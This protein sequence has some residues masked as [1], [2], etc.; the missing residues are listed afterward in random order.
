MRADIGANSCD[1]PPEVLHRAPCHGSAVYR[2]D[3]SSG[4]IL[5]PVAADSLP[6]AGKHPMSARRVMPES[7]QRM[8]GSYEG[9]AGECA[10]AHLQ[11]ALRAA[12]GHDVGGL[13]LLVQAKGAVCRVLSRR[14]HL[15]GAAPQAAVGLPCLVPPATSESRR[16][17]RRVS[18]SNNTAPRSYHAHII[19]SHDAARCGPDRPPLPQTTAYIFHSEDALFSL[20]SPIISAAC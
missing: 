4:N 8:R 10:A 19:I 20:A 7:A 6:R 15:G 12:D 13:Q 1:C 14:G 11:L 3:A 2:L 5:M 16:A 17:R 9:A 18:K